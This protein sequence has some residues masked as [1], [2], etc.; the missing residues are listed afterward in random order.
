VLEPSDFDSFDGYDANQLGESCTTA[1]LLCTNLIFAF[2]DDEAPV[3]IDNSAGPVTLQS[4]TEDFTCDTNG[5]I[6]VVALGEDP[7]CSTSTSDDNDGVVVFHVINGNSERGDEEQAIVRQE[8]VEQSVDVNV[9]GSPNDVVLTLVETTI[10][11]NGSVSRADT[12]ADNTDVTDAI[13]PPSATLAYAVVYD[14]DD[15][16]LAMIPTVITVQPPGDDPDIAVLGGGNPIED[17]AGNT[18]LSIDPGIEGAP[19]AHFRVVCGGSGSGVTDIRAQIDDGDA[20]FDA[21]DDT[22]TVE[23]TVVG[24]PASINLAAVPATIKCDG[25]ETSTVTVVAR[26]ADGNIVSDGVPVNFSVVALG[27]A[28]PI[29]TT[30]QGGNATTVVTPLSNSSAGVTVIVTAG[31]SSVDDVVQSS[32]RVDCALPLDTQ[33]T[34]APPGGGPIAPPDTGTGGY[35]DQDS[36][37]SGWILALVAAAGTIVFAGGLVARRAGK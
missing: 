12:C 8:D 21:D 9:V 31:D 25:T 17:I 10:Q 29:N 15:R 27:T 7:D 14:E 22:S 19:I 26:D 2:V 24:A 30:I 32:I 16:E 37:M 35:M 33:P 18:T 5:T 13:D 36:G 1:A 4:G 23:L 11:T 34:S 6:T 3:S 20:D 28:N